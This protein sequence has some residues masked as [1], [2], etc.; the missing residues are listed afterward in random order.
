M[1]I[2]HRWITRECKIKLTENLV[3]MATGKEEKSTEKLAS[4]S[5]VYQELPSITVDATD[6]WLG[7]VF[8]FSS[9]VGGIVH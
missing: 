7:E 2:V 5:S 6:R 4:F 1:R 3:A 9:G 8:R